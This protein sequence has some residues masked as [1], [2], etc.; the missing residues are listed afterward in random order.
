M[1]RKKPVRIA[2]VFLA[3]LLVFG[4]SA[5][6]GDPADDGSDVET[7]RVSLSIT[8]P[9]DAKKENVD[10]YSMQ[11]QEKATVLQ[12]LES[13]TNQEG[14][15]MTV[16]TSYDTPTVV[17]INDV[18]AEGPSKW[19]YS[20]NG[21]EEITKGASEYKLEDGDQVVWQFLIQ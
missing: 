12:I 5:C 18:Q 8:Y 20:V 2:A 17:S 15:E 11:V 9:E 13:Y 4:L 3:L 14:I 7:M 19:I 6:G 1:K 21:D 16:D 10:S